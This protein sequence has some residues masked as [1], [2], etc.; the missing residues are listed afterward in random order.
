[1]ST[2]STSSKFETVPLFFPYKNF[3]LSRDIEA[4]FLF[5]LHRERLA[6]MKVLTIT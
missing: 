1:M 5:F 3:V 6:L 4:C 2:S